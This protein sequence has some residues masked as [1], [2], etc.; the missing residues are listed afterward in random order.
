MVVVKLRSKVVPKKRWDVPKTIHTIIGTTSVQKDCLHCGLYSSTSDDDEL[1]LLEE[2]E[3]NEALDKHIRSDDFRKVLAV[4]ELAKENPDISF[5]TVSSTGKF[6]LIE[7]LVGN[8][9]L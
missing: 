8:I 9:T 7:E 1:M 2:Q 6:E 4:M 3:S 5:H